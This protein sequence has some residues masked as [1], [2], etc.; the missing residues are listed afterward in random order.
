LEE[1]DQIVHLCDGGRIAREISRRLL[2][3]RRRDGKHT[4][5][6]LRNAPGDAEMLGLRPCDRIP[7]STAGRAH[8]LRRIEEMMRLKLGQDCVG[9]LFVERSAL[10][11]NDVPATEIRPIPV[12]PFDPGMLQMPRDRVTSEGE[13]HQRQKSAL[14]RTAAN[15]AAPML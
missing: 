11:S 2:P 14:R 15:A 6:R 9:S 13:L 3:K 10:S 5:P 4:E 7:A 1:I 8:G 12:G